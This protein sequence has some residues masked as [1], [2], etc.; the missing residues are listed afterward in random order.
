MTTTGG[1]T[2]VF[3]PPRVIPPMAPLPTWRFLPNFVANPIRT[4]PEP[5][6]HADIFTPPRFKG[7]I[8]WVTAP[9][10]VERVLLRDSDSFRKSDSEDRVFGPLLGGGLLTA[11]GEDWKWQRRLL[12]PLFRPADLAAFVPEIRAAADALVARWRA[13]GDRTRLIDADMTDVTFD[14]LSRT[15]FRGATEEEARILKHETG[16]Y[17]EGSSWEIAYEILRVRRGLWHPRRK[18][19]QTAIQRIKETI[20][21][22]VRRER[23]SGW[24]SGGLA[25][26]LGMARDPDTGAELSDALI[27]ANLA[28]FAAAGHE[29]TAKALTWAI[30][31][32]ARAPEWQEAI[33]AEVAAVTGGAPIEAGHVDQLR[34]TR[35]VIEEAMRLYPPAP[36]MTRQVLSPITLGGHH[37]ERD[38]MI[39]IPVYVIHRHRK[40]W[41]RPD[42]FDPTRFESTNAKRH[43][44]TQYMPF[45]FGP[46]ICIG[47]SFAMIE[48]VVLLGTFA[49]AQKFFA[50][51]SL[52]PEPV[53]RVTLKARGGMP[54]I[55][56]TRK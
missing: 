55:V 37:F 21:G 46:R 23:A 12:A 29:T 42:A 33:R 20:L 49:R 25:A 48:A 56:T 27:T 28:T 19:M 44:R 50:D 2:E 11:E 6:Y 13:G 38:A 24:K 3:A 53:S 31:L 9:D 47:M 7:R 51:T 32:L 43:A 26:R 30:F 17:L 10:L 34:I 54:I 4:I 5:V 16:R 40:L 18:Q 41:D 39:I 36:V 8:A 52:E 35:Q 14:V 45:G 15:L 1:P 22:M